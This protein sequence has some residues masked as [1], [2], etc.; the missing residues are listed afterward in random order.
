MTRLTD[1]AKRLISLLDAAFSEADENDA[2]ELGWVYTDRK[3]SAGL[4]HLDNKQPRIGRQ[5]ERSR[6]YYGFRVRWNPNS[7]LAY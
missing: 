7:T 6:D 5:I 2:P 1:N 4:R 3:L